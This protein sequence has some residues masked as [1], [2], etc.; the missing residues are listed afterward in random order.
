MTAAPLR[1]A[2]AGL[3]HSHPH[4]D[5]ANALALGAEVVAVQDSDG[6]AATAFAERCGARVV[7]TVAELVALK[8]DVLIATPRPEESLRL[9]R[10][11]HESD[12]TM[13]VFFNKVV[14]AT[15]AQFATWESALESVRAPVGTASVL[16]FAPAVQRLAEEVADEDIIGIR[17]HVQHDNAGFQLPGRAWQDDPARGGGTLVTVGVH[18][19]DLVDSVVP[20]G[21]FD[22]TSGWTRRST[23]STTRSEDAAGIDGLLRRPEGGRPVP[24]QV[25]VTGIPGPDRYAVDVLT[26]RGLRTV[27][28]DVDAPMEQLGFAGLVRALLEAAPAGRVPA[29]WAQ[30]RTVVG[31]TIRAAAFARAG[32]ASRGA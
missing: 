16:R 27:E 24:A 15:D 14:A 31:N 4:T 25:M 10:G 7:R 2:F 5:A 11:L 18:A 17:V 21:T 28:L 26:A 6:E 3:A 19:W 32:Q 22:P 12:A 8:P 23:G 29:P 30:A 13:P 20:G 9:L 1:V